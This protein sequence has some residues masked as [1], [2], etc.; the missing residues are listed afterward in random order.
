MRVR[1]RTIIFLEYAKDYPKSTKEG[2]T[3]VCKS[4]PYSLN[5]Q[6]AQALMTFNQI[7]IG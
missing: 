5:Q 4:S 3:L 1:L 7:V 2:L 6:Q